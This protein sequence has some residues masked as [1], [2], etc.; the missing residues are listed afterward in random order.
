MGMSSFVAAV[1]AGERT[2]SGSSGVRVGK[3]RPGIATTVVCCRRCMAVLGRLAQLEHV[4][5]LGGM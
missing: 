3:A 1:V 4:T 2:A 5:W